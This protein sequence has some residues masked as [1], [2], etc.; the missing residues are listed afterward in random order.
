MNTYLSMIK[1]NPLTI[2]QIYYS[3]FCFENL[4]ESG[5]LYTVGVPYSRK[6]D[7]IRLCFFIMN[8]Y[9]ILNYLDNL[10]LK[11]RSLEIKP[12]LN[13]LI[14]YFDFAILH[15]DIGEKIDQKISIEFIVRD[16]AKINSSLQKWKDFL[17]YLVEKKYCIPEK[18]NDLISWLG[19]SREIFDNELHGYITKRI[20]Y[21]VKMVFKPDE[22]PQAKG[23][24]GFLHLPIT[25]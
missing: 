17:S 10:G 3:H 1:K 6:S 13:E 20:I 12:Y 21:H 7:M 19:E 5:D 4:P 8:K 14:D 16:I 18:S 24:F 2:N 9:Q 25:V 23:Y 11:S 22:K 15:L